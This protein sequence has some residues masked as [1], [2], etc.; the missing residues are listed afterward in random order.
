MSFEPPTALLAGFS[1]VPNGVLRE[2][3]VLDAVRRNTADWPLAQLATMERLLA[4]L[5]QNT[6]LRQLAIDSELK[7]TPTVR[8]TWGEVSPYAVAISLARAPYISHGSAAF[9]HRLIQATNVIYVNDEQ[10]PKPKP[11]G[12]LSQESIDRAFRQQQRISRNRHHWSGEAVVILNGKNTNA[13]G[14]F[15]MVVNG[16]VLPVTGIERTLIDIAVRPV[17]CG[18]PHVVM[19]AY[20]TAKQ[21]GVSVD[22]LASTLNRLGHVYPYHQVVGFYLERAGWSG[23]PLDVFRKLGMQFDFYLDYGMSEPRFDPLWRV[24]YPASLD[25]PRAHR[26]S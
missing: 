10:R 6:A 20:Q 18:G 14:V 23:E 9:L 1:Q 11:N 4:W 2:K 12:V 21:R 26:S 19:E 16:S 24:F 13:H 3:D 25:A 15:D 17:Y 5:V 8:Y 7:S 22:S